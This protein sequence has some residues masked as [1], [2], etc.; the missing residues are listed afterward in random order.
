M[1]HNIFNI[2]SR[3]KNLPPQSRALS[4]YKNLPK[5]Y[6]FDKICF[7]PFN[8]EIVL[9][10]G[11]FA[12][13]LESILDDVRKNIIPGIIHW[14]SPNFFGYFQAN[15]ST[16]GFLREM[17]YTGLN[18]AGF[19]WISSP[20]TTELE[21]VVIDCQNHFYFREMV[22]V[23]YMVA[24][25]TCEAIVCTLAATRDTA[26]KDISED[27]ITKLVVYRSN[28]THSV[29]QKAAKLVGFSPSNF[30]PIVTS[31][32]ADFALSPNDVRMAMEQDLANGLFPLF[33]CVTIGTTTAGVVDSLIG[34]GL[35]ARDYGV[36]LHVDAAYA[37]SACICPE[38]RQ[39]LDG[40]ELC[41]SISINPHK[42][43]VANLRNHLRK[44]VELVK[45]FEGLLATDCSFEV[46]PRKFALVG[47]RLKSNPSI[48]NDDVSKLNRELLEVVNASGCAFMT[49]AVVGGTYML[50]GVRLVRL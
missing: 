43:G 4:R 40:V 38:I 33:L 44:N 5:V 47:F 30:R 6:A 27:K 42:Y 10:C 45:H 11:Y 37:G 17:L 15:A 14:Q 50:H 41:D 22:E 7:Y 49:H 3:F 25:V 24:L 34:L 16:T 46:V 29:L 26:L 18:V 32:S 31:S 8:Q 2:I 9:F 23:L 35:V 48:F 12:K 39:Y 21:I 19:N 36:W 1:L 13:P 28:Q 20:T